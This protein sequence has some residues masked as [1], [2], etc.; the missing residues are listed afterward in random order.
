[1]YRFAE[2]LAHLHYLISKRDRQAVT[3]NLKVIMAAQD[4]EEVRTSSLE[5][6]KNFGRYLVDF[7]RSE[8]ITQNY[9]KKHIR[10]QG[11]NHVDEAL[12]KG[13][14]LIVVS[15]HM[16]NWELSAT[17]TAMSGYPLSIV[18]MVHKDKRTN[19]LFNAE[20][21]RAGI[22]II[23]LDKAARES[24][25][26][27]SKNRMVALV[28]DRELGQGGIVVDLFGRKSIVPR[29]PAFLSL[30]TGAPIIPGFIVRE[31]GDNFCF[32]YEPYIEPIDTGNKTTDIFSL[33]SKYIAVIERYVKKYPQQWLVFRKFWI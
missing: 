19:D 11:S 13:K 8:E 33:T 1:M 21:I 9:I 15:A 30:L 31:K 27:L 26:D 17:V 16:T 32:T 5:V 10:I 25:H 23:P 24:V 2:F 12:K 7:F 20:R 28:G 18:A 4:E 6:F 14:G 22:K 3:N 29:G